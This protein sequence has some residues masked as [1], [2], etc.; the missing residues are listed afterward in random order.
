MGVRFGD[1]DGPTP[2]SMFR[3]LQARQS[4]TTLMLRG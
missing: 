2:F 1:V 3:L 4:R